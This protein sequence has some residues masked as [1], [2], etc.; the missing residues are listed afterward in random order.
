MWVT[1]K[2]NF[3]CVLHFVGGYASLNSHFT[4]LESVLLEEND[5][6]SSLSKLHLCIT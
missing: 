4:P 1:L 3:L 5:S 2:G 6:Q